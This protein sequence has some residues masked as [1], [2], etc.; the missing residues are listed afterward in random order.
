MVNFDPVGTLKVVSPQKS[1]PYE[2]T[3]PIVPRIYW[4]TH[5]YIKLMV[6]PGVSWCAAN[7]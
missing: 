6:I 1:D 2:P 5:S 7:G 3:A 4:A